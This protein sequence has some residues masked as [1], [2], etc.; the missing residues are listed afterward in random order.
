MTQRNKKLSKTH[1]RAMQIIAVL[2]FIWFSYMAWR[3]FSLRNYVGPEG[4]PVT[5][6]PWYVTAIIPALW[7]VVFVV[8]EVERRRANTDDGGRVRSD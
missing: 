2:S 6:M 7:V 4:Q 3:D 1:Y 8:N 5:A